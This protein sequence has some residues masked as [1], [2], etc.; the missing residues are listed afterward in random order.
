ML[1]NCIYIGGD[2]LTRKQCVMTALYTASHFAVDLSCACLIFGI[3]GSFGNA[4]LLMLIYNFCA[5]A[6]QMPLGIIFDKLNINYIGAAAGCLLTAAG[7]ALTSVPIAAAVVCGL[8][9]AA[10]HLGGGIDVLNFSDK[11]TPCGIFVSSGAVGLYLGTAMSRSGINTAEICVP[12]LIL[13]AAAVIVFY[14]KLTDSVKSDNAE[15]ILPPPSRYI[16][17]SA[18]LLFMVVTLRSF[19]GFG[20]AFSWKSGALAFIAVLA[21][22]LGKA[23]GGIFSDKF[24]A[25]TVSSASLGTAAILFLLGENP[26]CRATALLLFN[27]TMPVTLRR[28]ADIFRGCK[29]FSFGMMTFALFCGFIP[30]Y[31]NETELTLSPVLLTV[32]SAISLI[33]ITAALKIKENRP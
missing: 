8:G 32:L 13:L 17:V 21:A 29:G 1:L 23:L 10:F 28:A 11:T 22:A 12:L 6:M 30:V 3:S 15:F 19:T 26:V 16:V 7:F 20:A 4:A 2:N 5:F 14:V 9:N 18:I 25:L 27:M 31:L 24:G 33:L